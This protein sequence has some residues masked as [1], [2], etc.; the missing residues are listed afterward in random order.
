M[1]G[2]NM[3]LQA[4]LRPLPTI[5]RPTDSL[6]PY[7]N[8]ARTH[9]KK[10][11]RQ[12]ADSIKRFGFTNPILVD[13]KGGVIAGHGR[14][15]AAKLLG[16]TEVPTISLEHMS[17]DEKRAYIIADNQLAA[18]AGWDK[19]MLSIEFGELHAVN[20]DMTLTGFEIPE[21]DIIMGEHAAD[22]RDDDDNEPVEEPDTS[23]PAVSRRG[24]VYLLG[25][26]RLI[27]GDALSAEDYAI[28]M[29]G[30]KAG[31]CFSDH[32]YNVVV[33]GNVSG[34]GKK[35]HG[36]FAMASGEMSYAEF[37][38]FLEDTC[39]RI[40][41]ACVPGAISFICMDWRHLVETIEAGKKSIG[42]LL[43]ICVWNKT[44]AGMGS[45]YRSQHE[46][47]LVFRNGKAPHRN[48][49]ELGKHG[50]HRS[51]VWTYRGA[52]SFGA[53]RMDDLA[54]H[55]TVKPVNLVADALLDVSKRGDIVLDPF[56]GSG[57]TLIAAD[58]TGRKAR[59]IEI[60]PH[61]CDLIVRRFEN[62]TGKQAKLA[63]TGQTFEE[64]VEERASAS[65]SETTE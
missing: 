30:E 24:D 10:Q 15:A 65:I 39:A 62:H 5:L 34:L 35:K 33:S 44:N 13:S 16:M 45:L 52:N 41:E 54:A 11:I 22:N 2:Y 50:R 42:D 27:C 61:Y 7:K 18:K 56:G 20:F 29:Q 58:K 51:N 6:T 60:D 21:I 1:Q 36:E 40:A 63:A 28:L 19:E 64:L 3:T 38:K 57:T 49:V 25:S 37:A 9:S 23:K 47:V 8:N 53:G 17:E 12:I 31:V 14:L 4:F 43:N 26:H 55:P 32:P 46:M 59:L 48:N